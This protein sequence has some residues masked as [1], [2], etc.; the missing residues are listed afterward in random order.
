M[1]AGAQYPWVFFVSFGVTL[2]PVE[3][4]FAKTL[5]SWF[6]SFGGAKLGSGRGTVGKCAGQKWSKM[7]QTTIL[8][9]M[10]LF[11]TGF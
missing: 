9:K 10:T 7:V 5:F 6:L 1:S 3:T 2:D 8:V 4:P 11:R